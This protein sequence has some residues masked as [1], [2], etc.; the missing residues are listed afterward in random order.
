MTVWLSCCEQKK[1]T[2]TSSSFLCG[3]VSRWL[4]LL[5]ENYHGGTEAQRRECQGGPRQNRYLIA[6]GFTMDCTPP[7]RR[8]APSVN[9]NSHAWSLTS[10]SVFMFSS[11]W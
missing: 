7:V 11:M 2:A 9:K 1:A 8:A 4:V 3:S 6:T 5:K 10:S